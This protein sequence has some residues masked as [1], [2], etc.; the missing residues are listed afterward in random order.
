M[1]VLGIGINTMDIYL[2]YGKMYPGGN[3]YNIAYHVRK[4]GGGSSFMGVF[5]PDK[6]G[7]YLYTVLEENGVDLSHSRC[8]D[9][10]SGYAVVDLKD[11]DR[12]FLDWNRKGVTDEYPFQITED[13]INYA[14]GFDM[15]C[16]S[17]YSRLTRDKVKRLGSRVRLCYDFCDDF[18]KAEVLEMAPF[19]KIACLSASHLDNTDI[20]ILMKETY[21]AGCP[22]IIA[23]LGSKGSMAYDGIKY[24]YQNGKTVEVVDTMGAG[25]SFLSAFLVSYLSFMVGDVPAALFAGAEYAAKVVQIPG[26]LG[27]GYDIDITNINQY[28]KLKGGFTL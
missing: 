13:E 14:S 26:S 4:L 7:E 25:D 8:E 28:F 17:H 16:T 11:G 12:V 19:L 21:K 20:Q 1:R 15:V 9:G 10:S 5:A 6:A 2:Q 18:T 3:E 22:L 23:T 27:I 24:Y